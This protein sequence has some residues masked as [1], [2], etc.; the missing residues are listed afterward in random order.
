[1]PD[2]KKDDSFI[3]CMAGSAVGGALNNNE[4]LIT[5]DIQMALFTAEGLILSRVR[6]EYNDHQNDAAV[7]VFHALLRWLYTQQA[8]LLGDMINTYGTCSIVDGILTGQKQLF[9]LRNPSDTCFE[10]LN[11]GVMGTPEHPLSNSNGAGALVRTLPAGLAFSDPEQAFDTGC[12][13]AAITHGHP[14]AMLSSGFLASL[15][16][17]VSGGQPLPWA[18]H[19]SKMILESKPDHETVWNAL[20]KV[21]G[22]VA[23][24]PGKDGWIKKQFADRTALDALCAGLYCALSFP[25]DF[26]QGVLFSIGQSKGMD[27]ISAVTGGILGAACGYR[28]IPDD[29]LSRLELKDLI[30]EVAGD[31]FEQYPD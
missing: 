15:V 27:E 29:F 14:D 5:D 17:L 7:P 18:V 20:N 6:S 24:Q 21:S 8:H 30:V 4:G 1:M 28:A 11:A 12:R 16:S 23:D 3:G 10:I 25:D 2:E 26:R 22:M 9:S 13:I 31:L 19:Q